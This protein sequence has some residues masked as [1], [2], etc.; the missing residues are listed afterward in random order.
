MDFDRS[1]PPLA[2]LPVPTVLDITQYWPAQIPLSSCAEPS[3]PLRAPVASERIAASLAQVQAIPQPTRIL[4]TECLD[5]S[6]PLCGHRRMCAD[7]RHKVSRS[8][9]CVQDY[10]PLPVSLILLSAISLRT[11]DSSSVILPTFTSCGFFRCSCSQSIYLQLSG[12]NLYRSDDTVLS[13]VR[14][15]GSDKAEKEQRV[16]LDQSMD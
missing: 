13:G 10:I 7:E 5:L 2:V 4:H 12:S 8:I 3:A 1:S 6:W 15:A 9:N 16:V 11:A 14:R